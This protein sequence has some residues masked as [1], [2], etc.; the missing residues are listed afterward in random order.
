VVGIPGLYFVIA[1]A[2]RARFVRPDPYNGLHTVGVVD[3]ETLR[4]ND[5][6]ANGACDPP[7]PAQIRFVP[8]LAGRIDEDLAVDLFTHLVLVGPP[9]VLQ[10][11]MGLIDAPTT[12]SLSGSLARDLMAVPDLELWPHL[13]S[14]IQPAP[15]THAPP[16]ASHEW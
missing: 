7:G 5:F 3:L 4:Q 15:M 14:W 10:E 1:R 8:R 9:D 2:D 13:L 16:V 11:L 6:G 12:A